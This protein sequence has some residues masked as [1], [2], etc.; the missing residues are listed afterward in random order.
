MRNPIH[1]LHLRVRWPLLK[2]EERDDSVNVN[3]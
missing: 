1:Q 3:G 2:P